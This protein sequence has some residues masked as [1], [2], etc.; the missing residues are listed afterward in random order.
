[1]NTQL[2][3]SLL[4]DPC[5]MNKQPHTPEVTPKNPFP[6]RPLLA[7]M[8]GLSNCEPIYKPFSLKLLLVRYLITAE[9]TE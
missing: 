5:H 6:C 4:P 1:M 2:P 3:L 8:A 9:N 7:T